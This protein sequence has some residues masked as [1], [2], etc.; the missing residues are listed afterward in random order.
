[1]SSMRRA[2][3]KC[4]TPRLQLTTSAKFWCIQLALRT[5]IREVITH[6]RSPKK[7]GRRSASIGVNSLTTIWVRAGTKNYPSVDVLRRNSMFF[8]V[9]A[10]NH[11]PQTTP[12]WCAVFKVRPDPAQTRRGRGVGGEVGRSD[13]IESINWQSKKIKTS[14]SII[15]KKIKC[16]R[17]DDECD[18]HAAR[19]IR[20]EAHRPMEHIGGF[21]QSP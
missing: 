20:H 11:N 1:M 6:L 19:A 13:S 3:Y 18:D 5:K 7:S 21:M 16:N 10:H 9:L 4:E 14:Y 2:L 17:L 12:P 15:Y 8:L